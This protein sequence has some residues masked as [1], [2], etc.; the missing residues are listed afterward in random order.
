[1][2]ARRGIARAYPFLGALSLACAGSSWAQAPT[3]APRPVTFTVT[4]VSAESAPALSKA[5][6]QLFLG[7]ERKPVDGWAEDDNL[8]LAILID[9]SIARGAADNWND[10]RQFIMALPAATRVAVGYLRF[11][12]AT[13]A[14]DFT[15]DHEAAGRALRAPM[16]AAGSSSSPYVAT[17]DLLRRWPKAGPRRSILLISTGVDFFAGRHQGP[18]LPDVDPLIRRA[19]VQ[20][21]NIWAV[22]YPGGGHR[23]RN[24][25][26]VL[27]GQENL[28][29]L[30][31]ATGGLLF[32]LGPGVPASLK[33][34]FDEIAAHLSRQHLLTFMAVRGEKGRHVDV[35]V[36]TEVPDAEL[37]A[38]SAVFLPAAK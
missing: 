4:T 38:P 2:R 36:R 9:D 29:R 21:T 23:A 22:F 32:A 12:V 10:L 35:N 7:S 1:M 13:L 5:D 33:P 20:N 3:E 8:H 19:Q 31:E 37:L 27:N 25:T 16:G 14:Q 6:V 24:F 34:H 18:I 30:A 28:A 17:L 26:H 11:G 15:T